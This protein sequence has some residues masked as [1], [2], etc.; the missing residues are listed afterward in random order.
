MCATIKTHNSAKNEKK[1]RKIN[2][3]AS[4]VACMK[5]S[6]FAFSTV[7]YFLRLNL[8]LSNRIRLDAPQ[9]VYS[10]LYANGFFV[11]IAFMLIADTIIVCQKEKALFV[12]FFA[13]L[14]HETNIFIYTLYACKCYKFVLP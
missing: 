3:F 8:L 14:K 2:K 7:A 13:H 4:L 10:S 12:D 11:N 6:L 1:K 5:N 9:Q